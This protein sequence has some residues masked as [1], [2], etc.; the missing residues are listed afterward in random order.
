[1][2][3][4]IFTFHKTVIGYRHI[5]EEIPCQDNSTSYTAED[6]SFQ[7]IAV[8]DGHGDPACHR[9]EKGSEYA[10]TFAVQCLKE[11][12]KAI[13]SGD[14]DISSPRQKRECIEQLTNTI[15]SKWY[16]A[17]R[18]DLLQN[19]VTEDDL[20]EAGLYTEAY[21]EGRRLEHL[22]GT[23]LLAALKVKNY[24]ILIHQGD[25][26]CDVFYDDGS[27]DQPI[28]WDKRCKGSVTTSMCDEDV[29]GS[30]RSTVINTDERKVVACYIGSD[31][32]EDSYYDNEESQLGTHRFYMDLSCKI[33]ELNPEEFTEYL[34]SFL[35]EFS[36]KGSADDV[37][38]AGIVDLNSIANLVDSYK[39]KVEQYDYKESLEKRL[40]ETNSKII[41]M[42]RKHGVLKQRAEDTEL[43]LKEA[44]AEKQMLTEDQDKLLTN[45]DDLSKKADAAKDELEI[46]RKEAESARSS[47]EEKYQ[48][49]TSAIH[50]FVDEITV[51][52][53]RKEAEY[54]QMLEHL[55]TYNQQI[56]E[57]EEKIS[58]Q[59]DLI[60]ECQANHDE[61]NTDYEA[62]HAKYCELEKELQQ[63]QDEIKKIS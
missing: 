27:V 17:I 12:A 43:K 15:I 9:S 54:S 14:M 22:Y 34:N 53:S 4:N 11:F 26:R 50:A 18:N 40:E 60:K 5:Q 59:D 19:E 37:S 3:D 61:A 2:N 30:I 13:C 8:G 29:F 20:K 56:K 63:I 41:S 23:T 32:V 39:E 21:R 6:G 25:G 7:I 55:M 16:G 51:G 10:I 57:H 47:V 38:I 46:Y 42:T 49:I 52:Y 28:P 62:Y 44:I 36:R 1:M 45:R 35:P 33:H 31:G 48:S 24:I 58:E